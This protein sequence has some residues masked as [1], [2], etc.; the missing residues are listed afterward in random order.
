MEYLKVFKVYLVKNNTK[1]NRI[2]FLLIKQIA[3]SV[4]EYVAQ[5]FPCTP[6]GRHRKHF[7]Y[8]R[9]DRKTLLL[10]SFL[11]VTWNFKG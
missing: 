10:F 5:E 1:K 2:N 4:S 8:I 3:I 11:F 9:R 7:I 6:F